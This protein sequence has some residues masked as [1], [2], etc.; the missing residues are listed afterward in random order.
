MVGLAGSNRRANGRARLTIVRLS[1]Q[2]RTASVKTNIKETE[3]GKDW[4]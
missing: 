4:A 3:N 2:T 1:L